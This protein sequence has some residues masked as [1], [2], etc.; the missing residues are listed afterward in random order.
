MWTY[1]VWIVV[2][3]LIGLQHISWVNGRPTILMR[4]FEVVVQA[5][6][7]KTDSSACG[8]RSLLHTVEGRAREVA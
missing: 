6:A 4:C 7:N 8:V 5:H 2:L 3:N 1:F